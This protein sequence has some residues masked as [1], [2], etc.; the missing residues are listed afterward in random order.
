MKGSLRPGFWRPLG[1]FSA[2]LSS[3][4]VLPVSAFDEPAPPPELGDT[5]TSYRTRQ[6]LED[7]A[8]RE[9]GGEVPSTPRRPKRV[10]RQDENGNIVMV[11]ENAPELSAEKRP[12]S[13]SG[14]QTPQKRVIRPKLQEHRDFSYE[15]NHQFP[16]YRNAI[17]VFSVEDKAG[18]PWEIARAEVSN[19]Y[20]RAVPS[21][22]GKTVTVSATT[23]QKQAMG[24][25]K[26]FLD[27]V[28]SP[29][30]FII[31]SREDKM[32]DEYYVKVAVPNPAP[33]NANRNSGYTN[34]K[35][36]ARARNS[37]DRDGTSGKGGMQDSAP[38]PQSGGLFG[39]TVVS[40]KSVSPDSIRA[41][42]DLLREVLTEHAGK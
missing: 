23:H 21:E 8:V 33:G 5:L 36:S 19:Q 18:Y 38:A 6:Q 7:G 4:S 22:D 27:G 40:D 10:Y 24:K 29:L 28:R 15:P 12:E 13:G 2:L 14:S 9:S 42:S 32:A 16:L 26:L 39:I 20:L 25:V 11:E 34:M 31:S 1:I 37:F 41:T 30:E 17:L 35:I 3:L